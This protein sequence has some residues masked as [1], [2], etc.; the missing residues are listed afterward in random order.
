MPTY[1]IVRCPKCG[2]TDAGE[3]GGAYEFTHMRCGACGFNEYC[4][5]YQIKDD[6]NVEIDLAPGTMRLPKQ[7]APL[8]ADRPSAP[9]RDDE[10]A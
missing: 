6:W 1:T 10:N 9:R 5:H 3:D 2:S 7:V 4:D 8:V